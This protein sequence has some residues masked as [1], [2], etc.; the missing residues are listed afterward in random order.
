MDK[1]FRKVAIPVGLFLV[2]CISIALFFIAWPVQ[3]GSNPVTVLATITPSKEG[4]HVPLRLPAYLDSTP[5]PDSGTS[6]PIPVIETIDQAKNIPLADKGQAIFLRPDGTF[7]AILYDGKLPDKLNKD[8]KL[9]QIYY[10]HPISHNLERVSTITPGPKN[11]NSTLVAYP[12]PNVNN[13]A[14]LSTPTTQSY[15]AP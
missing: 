7:Y 13:S 5:A 14:L 4:T 1:N 8:D 2:G 12:A 6:T 10:P 3:S 9:V 11:G 15:P